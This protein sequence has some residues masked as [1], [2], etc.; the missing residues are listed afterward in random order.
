[1]NNK[2]TAYAVDKPAH[3]DK[4]I[5]RRATTQDPAGELYLRSDA[6][7]ERQHVSGRGV[8]QLVVTEIGR[9]HH[10]VEYRLRLNRFSGSDAKTFHDTTEYRGC[11]GN[12][13]DP[14]RPRY[15]H[16]S[17]LAEPVTPATKSLCCFFDIPKLTTRRTNEDKYRIAVTRPS[18]AVIGFK[19]SL[20][21]SAI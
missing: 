16:F 1:M 5:F 18:Y 7:A 17:R 8:D 10:L 13:V 12:I 11:F 6:T 3:T 19:S 4:T 2:H 21:F 20:R 15:I 14:I 9:F